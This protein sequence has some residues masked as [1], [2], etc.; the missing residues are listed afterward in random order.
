MHTLYRTP[1]YP[2]DCW[3]GLQVNVRQEEEENEEDDEDE[4]IIF[5]IL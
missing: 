1:E 5:I 4:I 3:V 2:V